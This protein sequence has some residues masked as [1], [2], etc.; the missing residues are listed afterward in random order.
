MVISMLNRSRGYQDS[1]NVISAR[2]SNRED[3]NSRKKVQNI[4]TD[5]TVDSQPPHLLGVRRR[6][7]T[8]PRRCQCEIPFPTP[9]TLIFQLRHV[10]LALIEESD[11]DPI[12]GKIRYHLY[13]F[14]GQLPLVTVRD[15]DSL[16]VSAGT[17]LSYNS[18]CRH[19][20]RHALR[21]R[22]SVLRNRRR[23]AGVIQNP[24]ANQSAG[25]V[26]NAPTVRSSCGSFCPANARRST[27]STNS[28][29]PDGSDTA[30]AAFLAPVKLIIAVVRSPE[31]TSLS[32]VFHV[33]RFHL[34]R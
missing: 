17:V 18:G 4:V 3:E 6:Q 23:T 34:L 10:D 12:R 1:I 33:F 31:S 27:A 24:V 28:S 30:A 2:E 13:H 26:M 19:P 20:L 14:K 22:V 21:S 15:C 5:S 9:V 16:R 32:P 29:S 25:V 7:K 8:L 11:S